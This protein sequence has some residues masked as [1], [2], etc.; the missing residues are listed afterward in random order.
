M[1]RTRFDR[2]PCPVARAV[3]QV[4]DAWTLLILREA[5]YGLRRFDQ[6]EET[7]GIGRNILTGRLGR[8]VEAGLL[9]RVPYQQRPLRHEYQLSRRGRALFPVLMALFRWGE[10][11]ASGDEG[12]PIT[13]VD[14]RSGR[15]VR[16]VLVD[17][18][19]GLAITPERVR[20]RPGP[21]FPRAL[22]DEG[23]V[24]RRFRLASP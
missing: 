5:F 11:W 6:F 18:E 19:T 16:P 10:E 23:P 4:G 22:L 24:Q 21:G 3:D 7:L 15:P 9:E 14:R 17:E 20:A 1:K 12:P 13:M 2:W 8:M